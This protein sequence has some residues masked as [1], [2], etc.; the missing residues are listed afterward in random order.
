MQE[1][2][3]FSKEDGYPRKP[4]PNGWKGKNGLYAVGFTKK[5]LLGASMDAKRIAEDIEQCWE[6]EANHRTAFARSHLPQ[7][8]S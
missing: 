3:M 8:N 4:F 1:E 6:S 5:G 7:P 2:D